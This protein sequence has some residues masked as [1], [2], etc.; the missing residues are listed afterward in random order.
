MTVVS[1]YSD[2]LLIAIKEFLGSNETLLIVRLIKICIQK[3]QRLKLKQT[4]TC[5]SRI[6]LVKNVLPRGSFNTEVIPIYDIRQNQI[7]QQSIS[8]NQ[9]HRQLT[10]SRLFNP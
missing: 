5:Q 3:S 4:T 8:Y 2:K 6:C 9:S 1:S 7:N 10:R